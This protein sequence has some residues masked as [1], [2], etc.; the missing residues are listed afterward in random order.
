M[1][2]AGSSSS[3]SSSRGDTHVCGVVCV[4]PELEGA[5]GF[6]RRHQIDEVVRDSLTFG[7]ADFVRADVHPFVHLHGICGDYLSIEPLRQ[8]KR[9]IG[10]P[11]GR[12][13]RQHQ[14]T[15]TLELQPSPADQLLSTHH[16]Q[17]KGKWRW[18]VRVQS[19]QQPAGHLSTGEAGGSTRCARSMH[20][21]LS[22]CFLS[23]TKCS[24]P[25]L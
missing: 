22:F 5:E 24:P 7:S 23:T 14:Y 15:R 18:K 16:P 11:D 13:S 19:W 1:V 10:L 20:P 8:L 9:Q 6:V 4:L 17:Q 21:A 3:S 2:K 12:R 25:L